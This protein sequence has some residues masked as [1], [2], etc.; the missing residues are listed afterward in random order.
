MPSFLGLS[1][2]ASPTLRM[3]GAFRRGRVGNS[4][5]LDSFWSMC[6]RAFPYAIHETYVLSSFGTQAGQRG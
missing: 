4:S 1:R 5:L 3:R 6:P 2:I